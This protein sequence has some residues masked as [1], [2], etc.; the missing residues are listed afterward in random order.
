MIREL[1]ESAEPRSWWRGS[2][3]DG[4]IWLFETIE[5]DGQQW[6]V[7]QI[8]VGPDRRVHRYWWRHLEDPHGFL[9][10]QALEIWEPNMTP[11]A[12]EDFQEVWRAA[13]CHC[14][15]DPGDSGPGRG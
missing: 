15:A 11:L 1:D 10:D 14:G 9:T 2:D 13:L 3:G 6:V 12:A 4:G 8:E 7:K 5:G